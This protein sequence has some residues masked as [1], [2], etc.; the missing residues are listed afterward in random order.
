MNKKRPMQVSMSFETNLS[1]ATKDNQRL[2]KGFNKGRLEDSLCDTRW[3]ENE[4]NQKA[5]PPPPG[6]NA[7]GP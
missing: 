7:L 4:S 5:T 1:I 2:R 3:E 6:I